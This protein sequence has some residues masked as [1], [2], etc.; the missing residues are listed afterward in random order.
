MSATGMF[1]RKDS[2][3]MIRTDLRLNDRT[4]IEESH[5]DFEKLF[6]SAT[7]LAE[8]SILQLT[9]LIDLRYTIDFQIFVSTN[10]PI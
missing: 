5:C 8:H 10:G 4:D 2:R 6:A 9:I 3:K 7:L 1:W